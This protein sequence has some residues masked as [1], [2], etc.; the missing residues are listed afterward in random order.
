MNILGIS[1]FYHD[2]GVA[3]LRDGELVAAVSEERFTRLKHDPGLPV[4][5]I[6]YVLREAGL[7]I[8]DIDVV[9]FY[10]KPL[11]K[12]ERIVRSHVAHFPKSYPQFMRAVPGWL[13]T[14]L[15]FKQILADEVG[16][17]GPV[18]YGEHHLSHAASAYFLSG[19][20]EA[21]VLTVDGVGEWATTSWGHAKGDQIELI[22]EVRFPHSL[23]L[24]YS[25]I[26]GYLGFKVNSGEYKVMG[27][28]PY[29]EPKWVDQLKQAILI[30][31]DGSFRLDMDY[32][33][34]DYAMK[35]HTDKLCELLGGP[36]REPEA[37]MDQRHMDIARSV[38]AIVDEVMVKLATHV[39]EQTGCKR[40]CLAGGVALNC[41][42]NG[43]ILRESPIEELFVQPAAGDAGGAVGVAFY[44]YNQ[45]LH[46][47]LGPRLPTPYLGPGFTDEQVQQA[48][49]RYGAV[50]QKY[51]RTELVAEVARLIEE[52]NVIGWFQGRMEFGPRALG[53]RSILGDARD[54]KMRDTINIK[55]K[56]REGFR[57]FAPSVLREYCQDYFE[58]E[59][60]SPYMLLVAPVREDNRTIPA[61]THVDGSARIQT[62]TPE[63]NALYYE[64]IDAF[65]Q[66]TGC[67]LIINTSF[68][69]RGEPVVCTP[70]EG[71]ECFMRTNMDVLAIGSF[72]LHKKDQ[73]ELDLATAAEAFGLD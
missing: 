5:G 57:P 53:N 61:V 18:I 25:C 24:L 65:R 60:D 35:M 34:Y 59:G 7:T 22:G 19:W 30:R 33:A 44:I 6:A 38:Q 16:Y 12:F 55:I 39:H 40:L 56:F 10:D 43:H 37:K 41:V 4:N 32:F 69:V 11:R 64:L 62:V 13:R 14:K 15:R 66:R 31:D 17:H 68:N 27:L 72:V 42:A 26:T 9:G 58:L 49:D 63:D 20:D 50:Y 52:K 70:S 29:G 21:A 47:P 1:C 23:G 28:A 67:P 36:A 45:L 51:E 48:L 3:L 54:P 71:Y 73:P 46:K 8:D 2:S